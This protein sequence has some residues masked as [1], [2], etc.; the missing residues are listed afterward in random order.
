MRRMVLVLV[1]VVVCVVMAGCAPRQPVEPTATQTKV[2]PYTQRYTPTSEPSSAPQHNKQDAK[3]KRKWTFINAS[4]GSNL[5]NY[6]V[7]DF[8]TLYKMALRVDTQNKI[9]AIKLKNEHDKYSKN[10]LNIPLAHSTYGFKLYDANKN[11]IEDGSISSIYR[12]LLIV[13]SKTKF[14]KEYTGINA[15]GAMTTVNQMDTSGNVLYAEKTIDDGFIHSIYDISPINVQL[16]DLYSVIS[17]RSTSKGAVYGSILDRSGATF[18]HPTDSVY[19]YNLVC[20]DVKEFLIVDK[21]SRNILGK[22]VYE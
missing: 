4:D 8:N 9:Y 16:I 14:G 11:L 22:M 17:L 13:N 19:R 12:T 15:F 7:I 21:K 18:S 10:N 6:E 1:A 3:K 20:V 2:T 5:S